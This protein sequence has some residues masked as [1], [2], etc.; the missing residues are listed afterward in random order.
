VLR[1]VTHWNGGHIAN[2]RR[3]KRFIYYYQIGV[4]LPFKLV[5]AQKQGRMSVNTDSILNAQI[6]T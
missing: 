3:H 4:Y 1:Y 5:P 2:G 6:I